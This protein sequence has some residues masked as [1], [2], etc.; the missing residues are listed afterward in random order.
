MGQC[1]D[2]GMPVEGGVRQWLAVKVWL[3]VRV[4]GRVPHEGAWAW[5]ILKMHQE[6][7]PRR[8]ATFSRWRREHSFFW[9]NMCTQRGENPRLG[10]GGCTR[11]AEDKEIMASVPKEGGGGR[12]VTGENRPP[13]CS[14]RKE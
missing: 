4:V 14:G 5:P 1:A 9:R 8:Q 3:W 7:D 11:W 2:G 12:G 10:K 6:G 13:E